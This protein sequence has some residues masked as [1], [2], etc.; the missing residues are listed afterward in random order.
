MDIESFVLNMKSAFSIDTCHNS[1]VKYWSKDNPTAGHCAI[2]SLL[3]WQNFGGN[4]YKV[5]VGHFTHYFNVLDDGTV[6]DST[7][8]QFNRVIE[9]SKGV[10]CN[11]VNMLKNKETAERL[12]L[13]KERM[14][15]L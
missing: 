3:I 11:P 9:Y 4:V 12:K 13:L 2:A 14:F 10:K 8:E 15:I 1:Y 7:A 5:K 6:I